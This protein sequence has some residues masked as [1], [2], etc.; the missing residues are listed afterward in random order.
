MTA[1]GIGVGVHYL[2]LPEHP[3]Y[4][5]ALGWRREMVPE[6]S[7]IGSQTVSIPLSP[8]LSDDDVGDVIDAVRRVVAAA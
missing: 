2:G 7:R 3:Y 6:A 4:Q 5:E 8:A 1:E